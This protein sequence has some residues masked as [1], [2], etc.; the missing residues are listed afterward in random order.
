MRALLPHKLV[1]KLFTNRPAHVWTTSELFNY[2][3]ELKDKFQITTKS[4]N[5]VEEVNQVHNH[6]MVDDSYESRT[7][8]HVWVVV[9]FIGEKIVPTSKAAADCA[10]K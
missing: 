1:K 9:S 8:I 6:Q 7:K 3:L 4:V 2:A 5:Y 10:V